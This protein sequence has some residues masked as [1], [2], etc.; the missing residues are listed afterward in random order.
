[1]TE[2]LERL[3]YGYGAESLQKDVSSSPGLAIRRLKN[4][5]FQTS[6]KGYLFS[7]RHT[8][9]KGDGWVPP[10]ICCGRG[11]VDI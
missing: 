1:M 5:L 2:W 8:A 7:I 4:F 9:A 6:S 3:G 11:T 10:S